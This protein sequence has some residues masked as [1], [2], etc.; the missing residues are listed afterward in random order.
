M[1]V[2]TSFAVGLK[3]F[4]DVNEMPQPSIRPKI[5]QNVT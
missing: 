4:A 5:E 3:K 1:Y 2:S